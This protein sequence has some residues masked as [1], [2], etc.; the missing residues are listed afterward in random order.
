MTEQSVCAVIVTYHPS[1]KMLENLPNVLAQVQGLVVVDNGS[2]LDELHGVR[3][4]SRTLGFHLIENG[5]N[6]G[7][8]EALNQGVRWTKTEGYP[9]VILFDQDSKVTEGFIRQML[10]DWRSHPDRERVGSLHPRYV[11]PD[12]GIAAAVPRDIDGSLVLPMTSGT[13]MPLWIF[14]KV[15]WF[16]SEYFIDLVDWEYCFR[17]KAAGFVVADSRHAKLLHAAGSPAKTT[18]LGRTFRPS[19]HNATRRYYI[20]RNSIAFYREYFLIFPAEVLYCICRQFRE[21]LVCLIAEGDRR[22]KFHNF[23]LGTWDGLTGKMGERKGL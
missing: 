10:A 18:V 8:A 2:N 5:K 23:L 11:D 7:V 21:L 3:K 15:G 12:T 13:L 6:L 1:T 9:W 22:R 16:A 19:H 17:I 4:A 20:S 14:E